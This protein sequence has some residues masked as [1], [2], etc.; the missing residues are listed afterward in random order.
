MATRKDPIVGLGARLCKKQVVGS[1]PT[2][3]QSNFS[4]E[5]LHWVSH[6]VVGGKCTCQYFTLSSFKYIYSLLYHAGDHSHPLRQYKKQDLFP[7]NKMEKSIPNP[8]LFI[9]QKLLH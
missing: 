4:S 7:R 6:G 1:N 9:F 5:E 8:K 2:Q 3:A